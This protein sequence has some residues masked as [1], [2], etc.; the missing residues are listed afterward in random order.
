MQDGL[1]LE[2]SRSERLFG[3]RAALLHALLHGESPVEIGHAAQGP[4]AL[5]A[6]ARLW[7]WVGGVRAPHDR[8]QGMDDIP[9]DALPLH[10]LLAARPH[11]P[12]LARLGC[13]TWGQLRA[14]PRAGLARRFGPELVNALDCAYGTVPEV[15]PWLTLPECFEASLELA[16]S[17]ESAP[18]LLFGVRRLL[19]QLLVWLRARQRG[20]VALELVWQLDPRRSNARFRDMHHTGQHQGR[21]ELRTAK[22]TQDMQHLQRL[23][24]EQLAH[25]TL[26]APVLYVRLRTLDAQPISAASHSLLPQD[27]RSG[28]S[29]L[30]MAESLVARLGAEHVR[31]VQLQ[32]DHQPERMQNWQAWAPLGTT[33]PRPFARQTSSARSVDALFPAWLLAAPQPLQVHCGQPQYHG[34]LTLL[35]G[36]QRMESGW[37]DGVAALRDYFVAHSLIAG[38]VWIYYERPVSR[39]TI[40]NGWY[41]HGLFG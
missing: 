2:I 6:L 14:L 41:L 3:G 11:L 15:Y 20:A 30:Q 40:L 37:L 29:L 16:S 22:P 24:G 18:A 13:S 8:P 26:P 7:S 19:G 36:P 10:A 21:L 25:V 27:Q 31:C 39:E 32:A 28:N 23:F 38:M 33:S 12:T 1:V 4:T 34:P 35:S 5:V 17:V 9:V